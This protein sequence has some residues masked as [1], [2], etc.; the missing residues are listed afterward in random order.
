M[1]NEVRN[2]SGSERGEH[3][4]STYGGSGPDTSPGKHGL[5]TVLD[6]GSLKEL[7]IREHVGESVEGF[8]LS[9]LKESLK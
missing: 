5:T 6:F 3:G 4:Q 1:P 2:N 7:F 9:K 8:S